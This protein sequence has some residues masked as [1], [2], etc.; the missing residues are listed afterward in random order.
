MLWCMHRTNIY[1]D[2]TQ[3]QALDDLAQEEG[4]SRAAVIRRLIDQGLLKREPCEEH[5]IAALEA[6][7]GGAPELHL[8]ERG[9]DARAQHLARIGAS[10]G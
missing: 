5:D 2:D 4:T 9:D 10:G 1:L 8:S 3:C 7:F 6:S